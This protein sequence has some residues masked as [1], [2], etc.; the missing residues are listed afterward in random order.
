[1]PTEDFIQVECSTEDECEYTFDT[2]VECEYTF[3]TTQED[4]CKQS[5]FTST[6]LNAIN[7]LMGIGLLSLPFALKLTGKNKTWT[8]IDYSLE[9]LLNRLLFGQTTQRLGGTTYSIQCTIQ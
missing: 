3:D 1:M 2:Q 6:L 4:T 5:S 8:S 7:V 9:R